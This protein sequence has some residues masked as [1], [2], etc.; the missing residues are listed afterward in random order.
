MAAPGYERLGEKY[1]EVFDLVVNQG[2]A[3]KPLGPNHVSR[4]GAVITIDFDVPNPPLTWDTNLSE[5]HQQM[6]TAWSRGRGFEVT[7]DASN[8]LAI[9]SVAISG[10]SVLVTLEEVPAAGAKLTV[11]YALTPDASGDQGGTDV[12]MHGQL[13]DSDEFVGY[14]IETIAANVTN[15]ST[16][17]SDTSQGAFVRRAD[18]DA[19]TGAGLA[20]GT[21]AVSV[22]FDQIKLSSPWTG[23]T[24]VVMLTF[25]HDHHNYCVHFSMAVP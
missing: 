10:S 7:D 23:A 16:M 2:I 25:H 15:G 3:W 17:I 8:Q 18:F 21:V 12:G 5:P 19:V 13:R 6:N 14:D 1:G 22:D 9:A 20:D 11:G 4:S 24:G